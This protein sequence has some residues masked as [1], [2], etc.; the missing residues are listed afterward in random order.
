MGANESIGDFLGD[1]NSGFQ[2]SFDQGFG[3]PLDPNEIKQTEAI[4]PE[5]RNVQIF[6]ELLGLSQKVPSQFD[7]KF[8][9]D[10][11]TKPGNAFSKDDIEIGV[12][13][14]FLEQIHKSLYEF[15]SNKDPKNVSERTKE[16]I[17]RVNKTEQ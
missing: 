14:G 11:D 1:F 12:K 3:G 6:T 15:D 13:S 2:D 5:P 8:L 16:W 7:G 9:V 4:N 10:F 17:E